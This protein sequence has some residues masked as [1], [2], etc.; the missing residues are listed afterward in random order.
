V[1]LV[2]QP[3]LPAVWQLRRLL[4]II[5]EFGLD[6][7]NVQL[8]LNRVQD[9][10]WSAGSQRRRAEK[11]LGRRFDYCIA[12]QFEVLDDAA[13]RGA[14]ALD[15]RRYSRFGRQLRKMLERSLRDLAARPPLAGAAAH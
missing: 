15:V 7:L 6:D 10:F 11:A 2:T 4:E 13:N 14:P 12:D 5:R 8:A 9:S 3:S 1:Y